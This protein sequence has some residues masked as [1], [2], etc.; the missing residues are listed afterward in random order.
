VVRK[1]W[2]Q[3]RSV[4]VAPALVAVS[5]GGDSVALAA[6][7]A[8]VSR[9]LGR[10]HGA[11]VV[12]AHLDHG[13]RDGAAREA[14]LVE[15][16]AAR[17]E[18]PVVVRRLDVEEVA[19]I[20]GEATDTP[21]A[22]DPRWSS[23]P[24]GA[25]RAGLSA[26]ARALRR[27]WLEQVA[28]DQG[29][30]L[31]A[32][33]HTQDDQAE[34]VLLRLLRGS[35]SRG[36]AGML[37]RG[38]GRSWR[39]LLGVRREDLRTW[40]RQRDL[41]WVEDPSNRNPA[42]TRVRMRQEV[43]PLLEEVHP[44]ACGALARTARRLAEDAAALDE[45]AE[46]ATARLLDQGPPARLPVAE[47]QALPPALRDRVLDQVCDLLGLPRPGAGRRDAW[48]ALVEGDSGGRRLEVDA[49]RWERRAGALLFL[50]DS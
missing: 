49:G 15:A 9:G 26:R 34:T 41:V 20:R 46:Q 22:L 28:A 12:L 39:P 47:L 5:G 6:G 35:G 11:R 40:L 32:L 8:E 17:L 36:V 7:L 42:S 19:W 27:S 30:P 16:L 23:E 37:V 38:P 13:L 18:L 3:W 45:R 48:L 14:E 4:E 44:G 29:C 1:L 33:G 10:R 50:P 2:D 43:L 25:S 24:G 31:L 21:A